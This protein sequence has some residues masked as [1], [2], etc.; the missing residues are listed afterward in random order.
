MKKKF[1][2]E[3]DAWEDKAAGYSYMAGSAMFTA[4]GRGDKS[5]FHARDVALSLKK[6]LQSRGID[7]PPDSAAM[8]FSTMTERKNL[9]G[10]TSSYLSKR[11]SDAGN[12]ATG[13]AGFFILKGA[14][15]SDK[16]S[17][18]LV[19]GLLGTTTMLSGYGAA[20]ITEKAPDL[21]NPPT[22]LFGKLKQWVQEKP[23]RLAGYGYMASTGFHAYEAATKYKKADALYPGKA[24]YARKAYAYRGMFAVLNFLGEIIL[25]LSSKGQGGDTKAS[26]SI[27]NTVLAIVADA[28]VR[29]PKQQRDVLIK[30]LGGTFLTSPNVLSGEADVMQAKLYERVHRLESNPWLGYKTSTLTTAADTSSPSKLADLPKSGWQD[31]VANTPQPSFVQT[32]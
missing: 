16:A 31:R 8:S 19:D 5:D 20:A 23:N 26:T 6:E 29:Q 7:L 3:K 30:E 14:L 11:S 4:F 13:T 22:T 12:I 9:F 25:A 24:A 10:K 28:I 17:T 32:I 2:P 21:D 1:N 15:K 27:E 18:K